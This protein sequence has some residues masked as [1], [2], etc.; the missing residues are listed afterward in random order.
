MI[1]QENL[2]NTI[3]SLIDQNKMPRFSIVI[4]EKGME[5][6]DVGAVIAERMN[7]DITWLPDV[8]VDTI[9][10]MINK[11]YKA[12]RRTVYVLKNADEMSVNAKNALLKVTEEPPNKAYF[13]M[14]LEDASNTLATIKSRGTVFYM[15]RC[16]PDDIKEFARELYVNIKDIDEEEIKIYGKICSTP[17]DVCLLSKYGAKAFYSYVKNVSELIGKV[18]GSEAFLLLNKLAYKDEEDKYDCRLFLK[19]YQSVVLESCEGLQDYC[20]KYCGCYM[21]TVTGVYLQDLR[22]KG[23]N[24]QMLMENWMLEVRK[25]WKSQK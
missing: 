24:K 7:A 2:V 11:A 19:A 23:I 18:S 5:S 1:G 16:K 6:E 4:G 13:V 17:G 20:D 25:I 3:R 12:H 15:D 9:R 10:E 21:S 14:C 8:K 22:I